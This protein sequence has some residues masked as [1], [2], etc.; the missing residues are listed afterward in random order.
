MRHAPAGLVSLLLGALLSSGC[1]GIGS[2]A[3][4]TG[5]GLAPSTGPVRLSATRDP[6]GARPL[7][8]VEAHGDRRRATVP[9]IAEEFRARVA[10]LGG[11]AGRIDSFATKYEMVTET[12]MYQCGAPKMPMTC[13]GTRQ[14]EVP[15]LTF[16]GRAFK[17]A[18]GA[19]P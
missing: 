1:T 12:Y 4:A 15:T 3:Y 17:L 7:G 8:V 5:P 14:V 10:S 18:P 9:A 16:T 11:D 2:S 19:K 6:S 13:T